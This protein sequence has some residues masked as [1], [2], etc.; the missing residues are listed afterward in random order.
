M[1]DTLERRIEALERA[2]T[3]GEHD[4]AA[5][6]EEAD[7]LD[8]LDALERTVDQLEETVTELE[9][10][11]Q[12]L[13]GYVGNVRSVNRDVEQR[14]DAALA[15]VEKL[16]SAADAGRRGREPVHDR[17]TESHETNGQRRASTDSPSDGDDAGPD[18]ADTATR[19]HR[20]ALTGRGEDDRRR[21]AGDETKCRHCGRS[22]ADNRNRVVSN[23]ESATGTSL[24]VDGLA[25]DDSVPEPGKQESTGTALD[26][27][28]ELV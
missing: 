17:Q 27:I 19:N 8:R 3:D 25:D 1:E 13:R 9:A 2:I 6:T 24:P 26:R 12:A 21:W 15:K 5:L 10:A 22:S 16:E 20:G 28:R 14:A 7:A 11:T 18:T 23:E 4:L